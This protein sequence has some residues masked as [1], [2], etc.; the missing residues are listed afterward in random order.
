MSRP[1][2]PGKVRAKNANGYPIFLRLPT[3]LAVDAFDD[4]VE[5]SGHESRV[6]WFRQMVDN[7][8]ATGK[9]SQVV[10]PP[11]VR[12]KAAKKAAKKGKPTP[13]PRGASTKEAQEIA[14]SGK[15]VGPTP[16][17]GQVWKSLDKRDNNARPFKIVEIE[18][19]KAIVEPQGDGPTGRRRIRLDRLRPVH[20]GY[21]LV[22]EA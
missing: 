18:G 7:Y 16:K 8:S 10:A 19:D 15:V 14:T 17:V 9:V 2:L 11:E 12:A 20:N 1:P 3:K 21:G 13:K 4:M 22:S 5:E 6:E